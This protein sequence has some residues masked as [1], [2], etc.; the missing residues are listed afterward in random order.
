M[1][2]AA[3]SD[4]RSGPETCVLPHERP[5]VLTCPDRSKVG[6][7][8]LSSSDMAA[9]RAAESA[10]AAAFEDPDPTAWV[11][12]YTAD[13]IFVGPGVPTIERAC[14]PAR[15][16]SA[17][18]DLFDADRRRLDDRGRRLRRYHWP[19]D[20]GQ[21]PEG[22]R[23]ADDAKALPHGLAEGPRRAM[24]N[25]ARAA[26]RRPVAIRAVVILTT[27]EWT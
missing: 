25:R 10:L 3:D 19:R 17:N 20:L 2:D 16:R 22:L 15:R 13:A 11:N 26:E 5:V 14:R 12:C 9:I 6:G 23:S 18:R 21:R 27:A 24:A 1:A 7:V 4:P 8:A